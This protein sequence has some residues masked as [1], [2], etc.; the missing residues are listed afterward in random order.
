MHGCMVGPV[1]SLAEI[2]GRLAA[3]GYTSD[4]YARG[5]KVGC[6][7]CAELVDPANL[8]VDEL[9]RLE[10]DS[11]PDEELIVYALSAGPCGRKGTFT[12]AFGPAVTPDDEAVAAILR[13]RP[14]RNM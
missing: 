6:P 13:E 12:I 4:F 8:I 14:H 1:D 5:G 10:G 3:A 2:L 7:D 11:D 9:V